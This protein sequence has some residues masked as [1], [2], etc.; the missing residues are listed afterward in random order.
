MNKE[1]VEVVPY[2]TEWPKMFEREAILIKKALGENCLQMHHIGST[3]V[4]KLSA[5]PVIDMIAVVRDIMKVDEA[6]KVMKNLDYEAKGEN[7]M[8]FRRFFQK[9]GK[10]NKFNIHIYEEGNSEIERHFKF[11][12]W[13]RNN[14]NDRALYDKLKKDLAAKYPND[15]LNYCFGKELFVAEID[16]KTGFNG[17]RVVKALT[18]REWKAVE[19]F[20][21]K[22]PTGKMLKDSENPH[23]SS[24]ILAATEAFDKSE[25]IYFALYQGSDIIGYANIQLIPDKVKIAITWDVFIDELYRNEDIDNQFSTILKRWIDQQGAVQSLKFSLN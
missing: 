20:R 24:K 1:K 13:M 6:N 25:N 23:P 9:R 11:R 16:K 8:L 10:G 12:D 5:K 22:S 18:P 17:L 7:G 3:A 15:I 19:H 4:P 2:N 21:E 14:Q